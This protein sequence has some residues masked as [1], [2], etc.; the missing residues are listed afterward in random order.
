MKERGLV[1]KCGLPC[2]GLIVGDRVI[3]PW[4]IAIGL[5]NH[6]VLNHFKGCERPFIS[7]AARILDVSAFFG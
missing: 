5:V 2:N 7:P 1:F 6:A 3:R 4:L